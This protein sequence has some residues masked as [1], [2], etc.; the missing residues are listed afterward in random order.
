MKLRLAAVGFVTLLAQVVL[1]REVLVASFGS[2]LAYILAIGV[3]LLGTAL[4][5]FAVPRRAS[6]AWMFLAFAILLPPLVALARAF[7]ALAGGTPGAYLP[8]HLQLAGI[9]LVLVP[10]GA[11]GGALF[12]RAAREYVERSRTLASAYAFES[13]GGLA[14][15]IASA[16][17]IALGAQNLTAALLCSLV[18]VG[19]AVVTDRTRWVAASAMATAAALLGAALFV[20]QIDFRLTAIDHPSL[21]DTV[22]TPYGRATITGSQGQ[23]VLFENDAL[24]YESEGT[25]AEELVHVAALQVDRLDSVLLL[26]GAVEGLVPEVMKHRPAHVENVELDRRLVVALSGARRLETP[27]RGITFDDPR[28]FL[29]RSGRYDLIVSAMPEPAS[30]QA[31]RFYTREYFTECAR[32]LSPEGA[33]AFRLA[34]SENLW[35]PA[36]ARRTASIARA[37][38]AAFADVVILPGTSNV[39]LASNRPLTRDP[40]VLAARMEARGVKARLVSPPY[41]RYLYTNDRREEIER[42][43]AATA[44]PMNTDARPVCYQYT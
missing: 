38:H 4:G 23:L 14:G 6:L 21:I 29:A 32:N 8:I 28:R 11:L 18:A 43:I 3:Q 31:A 40:G 15:G 20:R 33:L 16:L 41:L 22:D 34:S 5:V 19:A 37:L 17:L 26:G 27:L 36:L 25:S 12:S 39:F 13:A 7:R 44:A 2:E 9:A 30:G 24:V 10:A 1:L 42:R 35:T